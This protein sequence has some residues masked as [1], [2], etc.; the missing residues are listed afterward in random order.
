[1]IFL[2]HKTWFTAPVAAMN[3]ASAVDCATNFLFLDDH[4]NI[5]EPRLKQW[6]EVLL[7]SS[8]D[9]TQSLFENPS[10]L[11]LGHFSHVT[12]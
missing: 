8:A 2:S 3:S 1:M 9:P 7:T 12:P 4:E 10:N 11:K 5:P 6:P